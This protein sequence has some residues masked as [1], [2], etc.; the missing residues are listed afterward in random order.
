VNGETI[1]VKDE[2]EDEDEDVGDG[3]VEGGEGVKTMKQ[4][5]TMPQTFPRSCLK[6]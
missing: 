5:S 2:D 4:K 3:E 1:S 6:T